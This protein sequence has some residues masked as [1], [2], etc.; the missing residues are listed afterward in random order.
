M[1]L[2]YRCGIENGTNIRSYLGNRENSKALMKSLR[3]IGNQNEQVEGSYHLREEKC[4][5]QKVFSVNQ[6]NEA[7]VSSHIWHYR[8]GHLSHERLCLIKLG[9]PIVS[10]NKFSYCTVCQMS[11]QKRSRFPS[12]CTSNCSSSKNTSI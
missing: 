11:K 8:L 5:E 7:S 1:H 12:K 10:C 2:A 4:F 9:S 6:A 3:K